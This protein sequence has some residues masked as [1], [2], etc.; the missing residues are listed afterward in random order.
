MFSKINNILWPE[1]FI[2][3][4][5]ALPLAA[6]FLISYLFQHGHFFSS[7]L[8]LFTAR[9]FMV[10]IIATRAHTRAFCLK[11]SKAKTLGYPQYVVTICLI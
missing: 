3:T 8:Q 6:H 5:T 11:I 7:W 4:I 1:I 2:S 10:E 9:V